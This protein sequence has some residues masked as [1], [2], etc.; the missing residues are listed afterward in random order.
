[1]SIGINPEYELALLENPAWKRPTRRFFRNWVDSNG[2]RLKPEL[3]TKLIESAVPTRLRKLE[4][5]SLKEV[6]PYV[7]QP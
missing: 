3:I 4:N 5:G 7:H 2:N 1:M 6:F